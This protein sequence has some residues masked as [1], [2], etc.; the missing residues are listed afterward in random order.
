[1]EEGSEEEKERERERETDSCPSS[2]TEAE[3][4]VGKWA[5][6]A[7]SGYKPTDDSWLPEDKTSG[8]LSC[9]GRHLDSGVATR[10]CLLAG[11]P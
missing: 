3:E 2:G 8:M 7:L 9:L 11:W 6:L 10:E 1:M 5:F 4:E